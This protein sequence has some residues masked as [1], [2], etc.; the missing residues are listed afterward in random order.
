MPLCKFSRIIMIA[1]LAACGSAAVL[2][3][4]ASTA[5]CPVEPGWWV[6]QSPDDRIKIKFHVKPAGT[7]VDSLEFT[8]HSVCA[9]SGTR[10]YTSPGRPIICSPW[11]SSWSVSCDIPSWTDGMI[12]W[13]TF[14]DAQHAAIVLDIVTWFNGCVVCRALETSGCVGTAASTW[15]GI[16]ALYDSW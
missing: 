14:T 11:G 4:T 6:Y 7:A 1:C 16:K 10:S 3:P 12:L 2:L 5:Q 13:V 15:G 8:L 9:V